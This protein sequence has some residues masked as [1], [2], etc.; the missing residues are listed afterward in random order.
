MI[1]IRAR[2]SS[3]WGIGQGERGRGRDRARG[4]DRRPATG[5]VTRH[6]GTGIDEKASGQPG[7]SRNVTPGMSRRKYTLN[8]WREGGDNK[9]HRQTLWRSRQIAGTP[10][11]QAAALLP[12]GEI[13]VPIVPAVPI[14]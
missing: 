13:A 7:R 12:F 1:V 6:R 9:P 4:R 10:G 5:S 3:P 8:L 2:D 14:V 11:Y